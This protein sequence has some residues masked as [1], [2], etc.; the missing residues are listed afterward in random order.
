MKKSLPHPLI[1]IQFDPARGQSTMCLTYFFYEDGSFVLTESAPYSQEDS[2]GP[3]TSF[4]FVGKKDIEAI[5]SFA[6]QW[7]LRL[8]DCP[9]DINLPSFDG[10]QFHLTLNEKRISGS[11]L[12]PNLEEAKNNPEVT[13]PMLKM[14]TWCSKV[15]EFIDEL[16]NGLIPSL[17]GKIKLIDTKDDIIHSLRPVN[18]FLLYLVK[19]D[20]AFFMDEA[21][22]YED[23]IK[24]AAK[25]VFNQENYPE[26][27][28]YSSIFDFLRK[29]ALKALEEAPDRPSFDKKHNEMVH[30]IMELSENTIDYCDAAYWLD[31]TYIYLLLT[32]HYIQDEREVA[33]L[34]S[35]ADRGT[36]IAL[37][38][39][40]TQTSYLFFQRAGREEWAPLH[41]SPA[42]FY[43]QGIF[44][45]AHPDENETISEA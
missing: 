8:K 44:S 5:G 34:H 19:V 23:C 27:K 6:Q 29:E 37:E 28:I 14:L 10:P 41:I 21:H 12:R 38:K 42:Y 18:R 22:T 45:H 36:L 2:T 15:S 24:K 7:G 9:F 1:S 13:K 4:R 30:Q 33:M 11:Y 32:D 16:M 39:E 26:G 3:A 35:P 43:L 40:A 31:M 20:T 17:Q 25:K